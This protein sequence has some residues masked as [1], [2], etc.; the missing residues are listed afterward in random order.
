[1]AVNT[2]TFEQISTVMNQLYKM[3][4][5]QNAQS[6]VTTADFVT[7]GQKLMLGGL[8]PVLGAISQVLGRSI[9][10]SDRPY[11]GKLAGL[12]R[13]VQEYG[14]VTRK[15]NISDKDFEDSDAFQL[16]DGQSVDMYVVNKPN[17]LQMNFYGQ[18]VI[19]KTITIFRTQLKNAFRSP[20]ELGSFLAMVMQ[21]AN[22]MIE[23]KRETLLRMTLANLV[24]G[25]IAANNGIIHALTEYN[26]ETGLTPP[27]TATTVKDPSNWPEFVKWL[28]A[29]MADISR[30]FT[31]RTGLYQIQVTGNY[32]SHHTP[33]GDQ[34]IFMLS[35]YLNA[36]KSRVLS[37]VYNDDWIKFAY[38]E[39][40]SFWQSPDQ[41]DE[42]N[43]TP[44]YLDG[45]TG[46]LI[47]A[48]APVNQDK[49]IAVIM[50]R[51]AAGLT[52]FDEETAQTPYNVKGKYWN[53]NFSAI[54]RYWNDFMEKC[55]VVILD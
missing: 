28:H 40:M 35:Q 50:D 21:N 5:G 44:V 29:R 31:E 20:D 55:A 12:Q 6:M 22:D 53:V 16:T 18:T 42:I 25:K 33:V 43:V 47:T 19:D 17:V 15:L 54:A 14:Y 3:V 7:V 30:M 51:D 27:L 34:Y 2:M 4:T 24:G 37:G 48:A 10:G 13:S 45:T 9:F 1:M 23:Q 41:V 52:V 26:A 49:I 8:D 32:V 36:I 38:T 46:N 11:V 39:E